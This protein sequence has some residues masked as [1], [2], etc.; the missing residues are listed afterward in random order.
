MVSTSERSI[1]IVNVN[2]P[3]T[4]LACAKMALWREAVLPYNC[5]WVPNATGGKS[6]PNPFFVTETKHGKPVILLQR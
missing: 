3:K 5:S 4:L 6:E 2:K 1:N